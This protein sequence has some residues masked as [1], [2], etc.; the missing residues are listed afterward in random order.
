MAEVPAGFLGIGAQKSGTT[1]LYHHL[2]RHP[3]ICF[4]GGKELHFWD[5][6]DPALVDHWQ[7]IL[8][9]ASPRTSAGQPVLAGEICPAYATLRP[10]TIAALAAACPEVPLFVSL[11]NPMERA[12][13]AAVM[14]LIR[15]QM[16]ER[17]ASDQWFIDHFR[18][19]ASRAR[20]DYPGM[21]G[22][23]WRYV[24]PS[25]LLVL[26]HD[27][28]VEDPSTVLTSL[29]SHL[30]VDPTAFPPADPA[31]LAALVVPRLPG[32][33]EVRAQQGM[34]VRPTLLPVLREIYAPH[35]EVLG[36]MLNRD[37]STWLA[38]PGT[39]SPRPR[40]ARLEVLPGGAGA[41]EMARLAQMDT[42]RTPTPAPQSPIAAH[43]S[44][45][46]STSPRL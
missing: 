3:Q 32:D 21:L 8:T 19:A 36:R 35:I 1:W 40:P 29:A 2:R 45:N 31:E 16:L 43:E 18:S 22:R 28:I 13:S 33:P 20:G 4:P 25:Q 14:A 30:G 9:P 24:P 12:W 26:F 27:D 10:G 6:V 44:R 7:R 5:R 17:E 39:Q 41:V 42:S 38:W 11:R 37:L 46:S 23:W 34:A 15:A